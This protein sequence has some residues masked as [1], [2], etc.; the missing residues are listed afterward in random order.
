MAEAKLE[1]GGDNDVEK[2]QAINEASETISNQGS[3]LSE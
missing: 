2:R 1:Q 3:N